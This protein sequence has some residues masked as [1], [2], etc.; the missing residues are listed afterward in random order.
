[1]GRTQ[2]FSTPVGNWLRAF[3]EFWN[4][5]PVCAYVPT[6]RVVDT[7]F[8]I[9]LKRVSLQRERGGVPAGHTSTRRTIG[10]HTGV[11]RGRTRV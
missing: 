5:A 4:I 7:P 11:I 3:W 9:V 10:G 2:R 8:P 1:M 6:K